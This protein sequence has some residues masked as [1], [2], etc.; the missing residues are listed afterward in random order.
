MTAGMGAAWI[1]TAY[2]F[3]SSTSFANPAITFARSWSDTF[4]GISMKSVPLFILA[5]LIG[6]ALGVLLTA[7]LTA[8]K[9]EE[10][11]FA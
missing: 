2:F 9:K 5:Q 11:V 1:G 4:S 10:D 7:L 6:A 3:T 8:E